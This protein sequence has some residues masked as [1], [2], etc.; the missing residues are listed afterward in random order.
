MKRAATPLV[1]MTVALTFAPLGCK[2]QP[3]SSAPA[4]QTIAPA[5]APPAPTGT[6]AMTQT[7]EVDDSRSE[8]DG[9]VTSDTTSVTAAPAKKPAPPKTKKKK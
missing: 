2:R 6:D 7:V 3:K 4:T 8:N 5:S 9:G 1:L